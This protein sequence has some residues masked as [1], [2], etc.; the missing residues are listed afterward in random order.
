[1]VPGG[2]KQLHIVTETAGASAMKKTL[3]SSGCVRA[4]ETTEALKALSHWSHEKF[5][6]EISTHWVCVNISPGFSRARNG[7]GSA[8]SWMKMKRRLG[9]TSEP[10]WKLQWCRKWKVT[11]Q[12]KSGWTQSNITEIVWNVESGWEYE[13]SVTTPTG[14]LRPENG[15]LWWCFLLE[16]SD[17]KNRFTTK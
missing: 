5:K 14:G 2:V 16:L 9:D 12:S 4:S 7:S 17:D 8:F 11:C 3:R 15:F 1:M 6:A 10:I 13:P